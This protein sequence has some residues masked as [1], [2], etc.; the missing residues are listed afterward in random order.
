M[1]TKI[2]ARKDCSFNGDPQPIDNFCTDK[3]QRSGKHPYC[4]TCRSKLVR[5]R[6]EKD[7]NARN[8]TRE[9]QK[10]FRNSEH[11][12]QSMRE[13]YESHKEDYRRRDREYGKRPDVLSKR[14][15]KQAVYRENNIMKE[16]ARR[17]VNYAIK[18]GQIERPQTCQW[19]ELPANGEV[20][21]AHHWRG[22][23]F[24]NWFDV[25]FVHK[26]CHHLVE[27]LDPSEWIGS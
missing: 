14:A 5:E 23:F 19:C 16:A 9:A 26:K 21:Q 15:K 1:Q 25:K 17:C 27:G 11:G 6:L 4:R 2:C 3:Q 8:K 13:Y 22:Y 20:L 18:V 12:K 24:R 7:E 10:K